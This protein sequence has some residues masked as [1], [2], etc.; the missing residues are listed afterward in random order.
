MS[1]YIIKEHT[2]LV[3]IYFKENSFK[4]TANIFHMKYPNKSKPA[5]AT[6]YN[7]VNK[8]TRTGNVVNNHC[9]GHL[10][11]ATN[12]DKQEFQL[13]QELLD[14]DPNLQLE[15]CNRLITLIINDE[16]FISQN[17]NRPKYLKMLQNIIILELNNLFPE[18]KVIFQQDGAPAY[19]SKDVCKY[20]DE[21]FSNW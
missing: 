16:T 7:L 12:Y 3:K 1:C 10:I 14:I 6:I 13:H 18:T 21:T 15:F 2:E 8:F 9:S 5:L 17:L 20:L 4:K 19:F 11:S